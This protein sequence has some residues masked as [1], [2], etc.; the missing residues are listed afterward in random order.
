MLIYPKNKAQAKFFH[1]TAQDKGVKV[2]QFSKKELE[3]IDDFLFAEK[4]MRL[5][6]I[7]IDVSDEELDAAF[8]KL[9]GRE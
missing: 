4:L 2:V 1:D 6:Q 8:D 3:V 9:L 7:A 5:D